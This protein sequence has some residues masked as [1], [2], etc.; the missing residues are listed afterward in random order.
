M[1]AFGR[2]GGFRE[3]RDAELSSREATE[4]LQR[5][6]RRR[7][8][9]GVVIAERRKNVFLRL[10]IQDERRRME[11]QCGAPPSPGEVR[12]EH[13][14]VVEGMEQERLSTNN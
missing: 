1:G 13:K 8:G 2:N 3:G 14:D 10:S 9:S 6:R 7:G 4:G 12:V 11:L 5:R